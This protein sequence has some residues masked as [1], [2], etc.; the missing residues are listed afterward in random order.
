MY[1]QLS[2]APKP[3]LGQLIWSMVAAF[4]GIQNAE[5]HDRDNAYIETVGFLP[6]IIVGV[7][8]TAAFVGLIYLV[9]QII[10]H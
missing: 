9:V 4:C 8:L 5:N 1:Q 6:Y 7:S 3:S 2:K 10:L